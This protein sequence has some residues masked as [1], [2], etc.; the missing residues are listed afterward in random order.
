MNYSIAP[1]VRRLLDE[2]LVEER[3]LIDGF[4]GLRGIDDPSTPGILIYSFMLTVRRPL[5]LETA[6]LRR[7]KVRVRRAD[8][9][10]EVLSVEGLD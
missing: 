4:R 7:V 9:G 8:D 10:Y 3:D 6:E 1:E 5:D 2:H